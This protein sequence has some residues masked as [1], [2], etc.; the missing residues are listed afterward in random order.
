MQKKNNSVYTTF[1]AKLKKDDTKAQ[2]ALWQPPALEAKRLSEEIYNYLESIKLE[3]K[4]EA[5][6]E[7]R[8][9]V[10]KIISNRQ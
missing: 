6:L 10:D 1:E 4:K 7:N 3:L 2:A 5:G 9:G 8:N